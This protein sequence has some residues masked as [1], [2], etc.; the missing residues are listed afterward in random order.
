MS[1]HSEIIAQRDRQTHKH[2]DRQTHTHTHTTKT[3]HLPH[4]Q[5]V[6]NNNELN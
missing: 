4:T 3:L 6:T 1:I 5:E 2:T